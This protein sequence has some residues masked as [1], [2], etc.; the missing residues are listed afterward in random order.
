GRNETGVQTCALPSWGKVMR[1]PRDMVSMGSASP[2]YLRSRR[3]RRRMYVGRVTSALG[4][5]CSP[6]S[7]YFRYSRDTKELH[8]RRRQTRI[9]RG[10][11]EGRTASSPSETM[12]AGP[13]ISNLYFMLRGHRALWEWGICV[14]ESHAQ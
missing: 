13:S 7:A 3:R 5:G 9:A 6:H 8:L 4:G 14:F 10:L 11:V 12:V 2:S 1:Y